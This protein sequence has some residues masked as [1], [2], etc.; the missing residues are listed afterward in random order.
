M[1]IAIEGKDRD[2][3]SSILLFKFPSKF[4]KKSRAVQ[5]TWERII[6]KRQADLVAAL[7]VTVCPLGSESV[8][9]LEHIV[10]L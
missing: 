7:N 8:V 1:N 4:A 3:R 5:G 2:P 9:V 10:P 6:L